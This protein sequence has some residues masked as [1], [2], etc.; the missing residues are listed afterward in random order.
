MGLGLFPAAAFGGLGCV[1]APRERATERTGNAQQA[2][3]GGEADPGDVFPNVV[4]VVGP[5]H[6][7][8]GFLAT[9]TTVITANHCVTGG[10]SAD[11][12]ECAKP[13]GYG[14]KPDDSWGKFSVSFDEAPVSVNEADPDV[15]VHNLARSGPVQVRRHAEINACSDEH[16]PLDVAV[17]PLFVENRAS[18][19]MRLSSSG[20][21]NQG[22]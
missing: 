22:R 20:P 7:C 2:V 5:H 1:D 10:I 17:F 4:Y 13:Y 12:G 9:P 8:T 19:F 16:A 14:Q 6:V 3:S 11:D 15:A 21:A 18:E